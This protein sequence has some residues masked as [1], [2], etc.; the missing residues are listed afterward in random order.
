MRTRED[1]AVLEYLRKSVTWQRVFQSRA[2]VKF[3]LCTLKKF[4]GL[5]EHRDM[6]ELLKSKR[7]Y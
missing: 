2:V 6:K 5:S 3:Y 4:R 7:L 1:V